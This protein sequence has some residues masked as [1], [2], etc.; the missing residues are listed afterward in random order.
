M[1]VFG[2]ELTTDEIIR[3]VCDFAA[4]TRRHKDCHDCLYIDMALELA[5]EVKRL[6][7][8]LTES[9]RR[10]R[11]AVKDMTH[12]AAEIEKCDQLL[13]GGD[14]PVSGLD[15]GRCDVCKG[16][17]HYGA[18]CKFEWHGIKEAKI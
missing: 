17:C 10:E 3:F 2:R 9:Q 18:G 4:Q 8:Q 5:D 13:D 7:A 16:A 6:K 14:E 15:L 1:K 12:I 11:V